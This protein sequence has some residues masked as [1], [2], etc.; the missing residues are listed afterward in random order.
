MHKK[1]RTDIKLE[2]NG[3]FKNKRKRENKK[4]KTEY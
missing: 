1:K 3:N 4:K 2:E